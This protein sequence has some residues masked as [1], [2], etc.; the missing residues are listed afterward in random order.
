MQQSVI[1]K[2]HRHGHCEERSEP[3][4]SLRGAKRHGNPNEIDAGK[5]PRNDEREKV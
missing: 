5:N 2:G 4:P 3:S 1:K